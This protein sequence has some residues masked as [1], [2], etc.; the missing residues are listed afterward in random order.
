[1][2]VEALRTLNHAAP[3]RPY[4]IRMASGEKYRVLHPD[5]ISISPRGSQIV[6]FDETERMHMLSPLLMEAATPANG[7]GAHK[8]RRKRAG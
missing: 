1:M 2:I 7:N 6:L 5:F 3:F 4:V 8:S